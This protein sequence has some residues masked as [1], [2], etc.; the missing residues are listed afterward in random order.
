MRH[1]QCSLQ[2]GIVAGALRVLEDL[3]EARHERPDVRAHVL[4]E[5][6]RQARDERERGLEQLRRT[7]VPLRVHEREHL[8]Q[9][10]PDVALDN[11]HE[12]DEL[13]EDVE[14]QRGVG[15][16]RRALK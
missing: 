11:A 16:P 3:D 15:A 10:A 9:P 2:D 8:R 5:R 13:V 6:R 14:A 7:K 1:L 4:L 12:L